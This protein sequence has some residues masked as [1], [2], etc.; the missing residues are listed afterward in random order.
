M[1]VFLFCLILFFVAL[2]IEPG[3]LPIFGKCS[4]LSHTPALCCLP[5]S[6]SDAGN[7]ECRASVLSDAA[8]SLTLNLSLYPLL[9][10]TSRV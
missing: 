6:L 5:P 8:T 4:V 9:Q 1:Y 2:A 7:C 10:K 3:A